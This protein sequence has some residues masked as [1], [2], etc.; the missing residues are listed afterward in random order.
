[1]NIRTEKTACGAYAYI[2]GDEDGPIGG[3][4]TR[5]DARDDLM[6]Q[7]DGPEMVSWQDAMEPVRCP[8][9]RAM[10]ACRCENED[11]YSR[12]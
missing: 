1:M 10:A 12:G 3:G 8:E 5:Q 4:L 9:C 7:L 11:A 2:D 6:A